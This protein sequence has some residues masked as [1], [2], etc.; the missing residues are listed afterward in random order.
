M[1]RSDRGAPAGPHRAARVI[2]ADPVDPDP[3]RDPADRLATDRADRAGQVAPHPV[4]RAALVDRAD[5]ADLDPTDRAD[6]ADRA[7]LDPTDRA[8]PAVLAD[9]A[10]HGTATPSAATSTE[11]RGET[12]PHPGDRVSRRRRHGTGRFHR[13]VERG[14]TAR[15]TTGATRKLRCGIPS[16]TSGASISSESG[17]RSNES[18]HATPASPGRRGGRCAVNCGNWVVPLPEHVT[19]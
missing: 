1:V 4:D 3:D 12:D 16:S 5:R 7:D 14:T 18:P 19:M 6:P 8:D 17:F 2:R 10:A 13:P 9:R 15:S 11:R